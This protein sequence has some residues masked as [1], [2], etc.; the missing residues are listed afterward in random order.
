MIRFGCWRAALVGVYR[1][2]FIS[3]SIAPLA[4]V[5]G[6][7]HGAADSGG[8]FRRKDALRVV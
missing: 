3:W 1:K 5:E 8:H 7:L 6:N 4:L 2:P